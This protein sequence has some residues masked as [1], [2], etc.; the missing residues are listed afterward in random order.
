MNASSLAARPRSLRRH[1]AVQHPLPGRL[2]RMTVCFSAPIR[3]PCCS[4]SGRV[5]PVH[6]RRS[7]R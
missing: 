4:A 3:R 1:I 6:V 5:V 2:V 7:C